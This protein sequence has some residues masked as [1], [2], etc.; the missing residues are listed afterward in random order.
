MSRI[1]HNQGAEIFKMLVMGW[2]MR[3]DHIHQMGEEL[4]KSLMEDLALHMNQINTSR[5]RWPDLQKWF[6]KIC[7]FQ[8]EDEQ[9]FLLDLRNATFL[10]RKEGEDFSFAHYSFQEYFLALRLHRSLE[11]RDPAVWLNVKPSKATFEFLVQ[12]HHSC[13]PYK[14]EAISEWLKKS[15]GGHELAK[16]F[17]QLS[18]ILEVE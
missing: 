13:L 12:H 7:T 4:K 5:I 2:L 10:V 16:E 17:P 14:K 9:R 15:S 11:E 1:E 8:P 6:C 3:D 18:E